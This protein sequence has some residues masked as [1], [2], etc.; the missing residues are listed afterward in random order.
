MA[1]GLS[2]VCPEGHKCHSGLFKDW[3]S[4]QAELQKTGASYHCGECCKD[5]LYDPD[6]KLSFWRRWRDEETGRSR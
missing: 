3:R 6:E 1:R 5:Y 4:A 2:Q